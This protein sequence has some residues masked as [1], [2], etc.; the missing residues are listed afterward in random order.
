MDKRGA[1][2]GLLATIVLLGACSQQQLGFPQTP[3]AAVSPDGRSIAFVRNHASIDP[4]AQSLWIGP[5]DGPA[6]KLRT[7][8]PD[9]GWCNLIVWSQ[10]SSTVSFL[11][12]DAR[13][14][15]VDALTGRITSEKWLTAW[16]GEYPPYRIVRNL[17]LTA[18]GRQALYQ[19]CERRITRP[20]YDHEV[21][22]CGEIQTAAIR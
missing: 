16:K 13:L 19:D 11:V 7:L 10:D 2:Y 12:Q 20:G 4:P 8:G 3:V 17:A 9:S 21:D 14:V 15:T 1:G 18:S 5:V 6:T 22:D